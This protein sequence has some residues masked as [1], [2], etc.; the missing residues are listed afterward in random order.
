MTDEQIKEIKI[1]VE[2]RKADIEGW[3]F[4]RRIPWVREELRRAPDG[5]DYELLLQQLAR[6]LQRKA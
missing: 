2:Q 5:H 6:I 1:L 4:F 3:K